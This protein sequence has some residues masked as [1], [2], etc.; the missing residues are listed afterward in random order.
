MTFHFFQQICDSNSTECCVSRVSWLHADKMNFL[1]KAVNRCVSRRHCSSEAKKSQKVTSLLFGKY[2]LA[3]NTLSSGL[4]MVVG[5]LI[6][7][8]IEYRTGTVKERY[9]WKRTGWCE[10][11]DHLCFS[12][13]IVIV[14]KGNMFIVGTLRGPLLHYFYGWLDKTIKIVSFPNVTMKIILDQTIMSP[15]TILAFFYPA[16]WLEGQSTKNINVEVKD[17]FTKAYVVGVTLVLI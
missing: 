12:I 13:S 17:K 3:T 7:Q 11:Y 10:R 5:D 14:L 2:L 4:L 1:R 9:N 8:E 15:I 16:G 6:S